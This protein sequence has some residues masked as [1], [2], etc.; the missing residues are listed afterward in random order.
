MIRRAIWSINGEKDQMFKATKYSHMLLRKRDKGNEATR[1]KAK[2][3]KPLHAASEYKIQ[4][5]AQRQ[6]LKDRET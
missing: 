1:Q 4:L 3:R 6:K 2:G 5:K